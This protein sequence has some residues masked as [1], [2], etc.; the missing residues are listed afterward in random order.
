MAGALLLLLPSGGIVACAACFD[1]AVSIC[2]LRCPTLPAIATSSL[3]MNE[4]QQVCCATC[5]KLQ[6]CHVQCDRKRLA[7]RGNRNQGAGR[8]V[9]EE[10]G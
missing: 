4:Q 7:K 1:A 8:G 9:E 6:C 2:L 3:E 10:L 5:S